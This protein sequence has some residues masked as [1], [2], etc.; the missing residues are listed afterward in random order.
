MGS[1]VARVRP[2]APDPLNT[3]PLRAIPFGSFRLRRRP[4]RAPVRSTTTTT[5]TMMMMMNCLLVPLVSV[6]PFD[7]DD[8]CRPCVPCPINQPTNQPTNCA[9]RVPVPH[10]WRT[11]KTDIF[12]TEMATFSRID[13]RLPLLHTKTKPY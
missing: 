2:S 9:N 6:F 8:D 13:V 1:F 11:T 10:R 3:R 4:C 5:T 12:F 7:F